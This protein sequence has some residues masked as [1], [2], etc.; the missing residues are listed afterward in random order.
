MTVALRCVASGFLFLLLFGCAGTA[1]QR[2][3]ETAGREATLFKIEDISKGLPTEGLWRQNAALADIRR[4]GSLAII[5]PPPRK[6]KPEQKRPFVFAWDN[7]EERWVEQNLGFPPLQDYGYGGIAVGD[8][9]GDGRLDIALAVHSGRIILLMNDGKGGFTEA[10]LP[11]RQDFQSRTIALADINGDGLPDVIALSEFS[12]LKRP[13][14]KTKRDLL[15]IPKGIVVGINK[16]G[17]EWDIREAEGS[18]RLFGD[19]LAVGNVTGGSVKDLLIAV[20]TTIE[21]ISNRV[22]WIGDEKGDYSF[23]EHTTDALKGYV[24]TSVKAGDVDG[25]GRDEAVFLRGLLA[26]EKSKMELRAYK[27]NG[28]GLMELAAGPDPKSRP[29]VFSLFDIDGDGRDELIALC[30]DGLHL[31]KYDGKSWTEIATHNIPAADTTGAQG[32]TVGKTSEGSVII[33]YNLGEEYPGEN[34]GL[35]AFRVTVK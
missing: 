23:R 32:L 35:R 10:P 34:T 17:G 18:A 27:W 2:S 9:N 26:G 5:A 11:V 4:D 25:D 1:V 20:Y 19:S 28:D 21:S 7:K 33:V 24:V 13:G 8:I 15:Q 6:A 30:E 22:L 31:Y 14:D 16:S 29:I 3:G 12:A